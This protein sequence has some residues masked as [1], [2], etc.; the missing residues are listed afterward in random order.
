MKSR[1]VLL[2]L[3]VGFAMCLAGTATAQK[4]NFQNDKLVEIGPDNIGGRVTTLVVF[5]HIDESTST[6]YAGAANGGL[7][8]RTDAQS[9]S[10]RYL[11]CFVN[12]AE[13]TLPVSQIVKLNDNTLFVA[14]GGMATHDL[15]DY[16]FGARGRGL[17]LFNTET[18]EFTAINNTDP[19]YASDADFAVIHDAKQITMQGVTYLY[20]ATNN[21]LYRW[22]VASLADFGNRPVKVFDGE[23]HSVVLSHQFNRAFFTSF[24]HV[25]KISDIINASAPVDIT[26]SCDDFTASDV[27][28]VKLALAPSDESYLY[29][30]VCSNV[31][32]GVYLTRNTNSWSLISS[33]TV[34]PFSSGVVANVGAAPSVELTADAEHNGAIVVSPYDPTKVIIGGSTVWTG[35]GYVEGA[36]YQWSAA[37]MNEYTLNSGDYMAYVYSSSAFVHSGINQIVP[38]SRWNSETET[39][40]EG[41]F[42]ATDGGV[43]YS[44]RAGLN[45]YENFS[46]GMNNVE[47]NSL[48]VCPDGSIISGAHRNACPFI[49]ARVDHNGG[50]NDSTWY[51]GSR[52]NTNH[53]GNIL[54][55]GNGGGVA[56]SMFNQYKP[57]SRRPIVV[58]SGN[59]AIGRAYADFSNYNNTQT[60]TSER[61]FTADM[62]EGGPKTSQLYLWE[63]MNNTRS[64]ESVT[65]TIDTLS[66]IHRNGEVMSLGTNFQIKAGD[67]ISVLDP[68]HAYYPFWHVFD[69]NFTVRDEMRQTVRSPYAGRLVAVTTEKDFPKNTNVTFTWAPTDF[70]KAVASPGE[71]SSIN[72]DERFWSHIYGVNGTLVADYSVFTTAIS[73][74]GDCAFVIVQNDKEKTSF[75][76]RVRGLNNVDYTATTHEIRDAVNYKIRSRVT[77]TDTVML[78]DTNYH[79]AGRVSSIA[80]DPRQGKDAIVLTIDLAHEGYN[81][82]YIN[83]ATSDNPTISYLTAANNVPAYSAMIEKTTGEVYVGT[84]E[85]VFKAASITSPNWQAYGAFNGVPVTAMYQVTSNNRMIRHIGHDGVTEV[86][87]IFPSTKWS[88]AMYFGTY[89]RGI[90][91]DTTYVV[92][93]TNE[94]VTPDVYLDIPT[95]NANGDNSVRFYPNPAVDNA[96]MELNIGKAGNA[97]LVVYDLTGKVVMTENLGRL[98][99]GTHTRSIDCQNLQHGMYLV[100]VLV[101]GQKATSKL[102]VR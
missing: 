35:K 44:N 64:N 77:V 37:S 70:R 27:K 20:V 50:A 16:Y 38:D 97:T 11:P 28:F 87:Y 29:A 26:S 66:T 78:N 32:K 12:G 1:K 47:I 15:K 71:S 53:M 39:M 99:E 69:H 25:Y 30:M 95:V 75:L 51:D 17:F 43:F 83:N 5:N 40:Y 85:G 90:F 100:N 101:G 98:A 52:S 45:Y 63:T 96:T 73:N 55:K 23:V 24:N 74:D 6:L 91:M 102:I 41:Y 33:S 31:L 60:W 7:Y 62:V 8:T 19:A 80:V 3:I 82:V 56:A 79:F 84:Q 49:E 89:G 14:T 81:V 94:I 65:F 68:A 72:D 92:D 2:G 9:D 57:L 88:N 58:S 61:F 18:E 42:I 59:G 46:R 67:S 21:G 54:W 76:A 93:H 48:A 36:P 10:W 13:V 22:N 4:A 86:E 34:A